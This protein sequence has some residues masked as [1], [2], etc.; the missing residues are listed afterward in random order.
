MGT[1]LEFAYIYMFI[2]LSCFYFSAD[3]VKLVPTW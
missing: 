2:S 3:H 1:L